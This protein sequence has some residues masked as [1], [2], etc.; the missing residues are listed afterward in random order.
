MTFTSDDLAVVMS[1]ASSDPRGRYSCGSVAARACR[2][3]RQRRQ[4][5]GELWS[6]RQARQMWWWLWDAL[7]RPAPPH[8][9]P[10]LPRRRRTWQ[11]SHLSTATVGTAPVHCTSTPA[12]LTSSHVA[13]TALTRGQGAAGASE[14]QG[15]T[16]CRLGGPAADPCQRCC[17]GC[18]G[19]GCC[20]C[21]CGQQACVRACVE[22]QACA[23]ALVQSDCV[24]LAAHLQGRERGS[25]K[26]RTQGRREQA[27]S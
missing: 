1:V 27:G 24:H 10:T 17:G 5:V 2:W 13:T 12:Q 20:G 14:R 7:R 4:H 26:Q 18:G 25:S 9:R 6:G 22:E 23:G 11:P 21:G 19:S 3:V 16:T 8:C 15:E